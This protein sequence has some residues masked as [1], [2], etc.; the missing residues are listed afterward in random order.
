M[1]EYGKASTQNEAGLVPPASKLYNNNQ[2]NQN[3][4]L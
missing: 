4:I 1:M 3:I 2:Q